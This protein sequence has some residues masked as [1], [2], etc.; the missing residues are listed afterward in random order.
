MNRRPRV[1]RQIVAETDLRW[2]RASFACKRAAPHAARALLFGATVG[3]IGVIAKDALRFRVRPANGTPWSWFVQDGAR[4]WRVSPNAAAGGCVVV[5]RAHGSEWASFSS[6]RAMVPGERRLDGHVVIG[7][8]TTPHVEPY[9]MEGNPWVFTYEGTISD[10]E[11]MRAAID[12][13]WIVYGPLQKPGDYL[14]VHLLKHL[15][16]VGPFVS[17]DL[18][19]IRATSELWLAGTLGELAFVCSDGNKMYAYAL[20]RS[21]AVAHLRG[22]VVVGTPDLL[23]E[24]VTI[25]TVISGELVSIGREP[26]RRWSVLVH[27]S[28]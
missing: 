3:L 2:N 26:L 24:G 11:A 12:P 6:K 9:T 21:L 22:A 5:H 15:A 20:G 10:G 23:P 1:P 25:E 4:T 8:V 17:S 18:A 13:A 27:R 16:R 28:P 14:F 19:M 7:S